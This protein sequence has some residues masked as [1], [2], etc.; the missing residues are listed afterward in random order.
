MFC[1]V[2]EFLTRKQEAGEKNL[3]GQLLCSTLRYQDMRPTNFGLVSASAMKGSGYGASL[4]NLFR[5][6]TR[7][8]S[9]RYISCASITSL[10]AKA[11]H[12]C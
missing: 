1:T 3:A 8:L 2:Q 4:L 10:P 7:L 9:N 6:C 12:T 5:I 11:L